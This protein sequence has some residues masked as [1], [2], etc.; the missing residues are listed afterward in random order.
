[1]GSGRLIFTTWHNPRLGRLYAGGLRAVRASD[2]SDEGGW[3]LPDD[4]GGLI[5]LGRGLLVGDLVLWPDGTRLEQVGPVAEVV[6]PS[7]ARAPLDG[8]P[9]SLGGGVITLARARETATAAIPDACATTT[10]VDAWS[11]EVGVTTVD[12]IG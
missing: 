4:G 3:S 8:G 10:V 1:M 2:G 7:G 11:I 5:P 12:E 6:L 9:V